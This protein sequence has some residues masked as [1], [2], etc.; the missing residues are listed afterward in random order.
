MGEPF[1][2]INLAFSSKVKFSSVVN[3]SIS[4]SVYLEKINIDFKFTYHMLRAAIIEFTTYT[5]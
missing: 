3:A 1:S 2:K 4:S 5:E